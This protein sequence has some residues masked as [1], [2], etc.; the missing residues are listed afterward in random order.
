[1]SDEIF[2]LC[3][4]V[5][6][7]WVAPAGNK[8][9]ST[10]S[11]LFHKRESQSTYNVKLRS[12]ELPFLVWEIYKRISYC[13]CVLVTLSIQHVMRMRRIIFLMAHRAV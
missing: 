4:A 10:F 9:V 6:K 13:E 2:R 1:V 7:C 5:C 12:Y 3:V 11:C 8:I